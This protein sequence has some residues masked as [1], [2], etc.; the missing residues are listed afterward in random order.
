MLCS[1]SYCLALALL[2]CCGHISSSSNSSSTYSYSSSTIMLCKIIHVIMIEW[3][4]SLHHIR[5]RA[6][7]NTPSSL[8]YFKCSFNIFP[9]HF[10]HLCKKPLLRVI[11]RRDGFHQNSPTRVDLICQIV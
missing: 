1:S 4:L 2:D 11:R 9:I 5:A 8:Q 3:R 10:L 7:N 6:P